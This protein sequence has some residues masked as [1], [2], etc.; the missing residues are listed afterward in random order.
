M[1]TIITVFRAESQSQGEKIQRSLEDHIRKFLATA[2]GFRSAE[3]LLGENHSRVALIEKWSSRQAPLSRLQ[4][5]ELGASLAHVAR[6]ALSVEAM[7]FP[8]SEYVAVQSAD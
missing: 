8:E 1:S 2:P 3:V 6:E 5:E 7:F 4:D